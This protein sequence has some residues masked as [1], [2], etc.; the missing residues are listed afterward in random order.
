VLLRLP[1]EVK[2]LFRE[3]LAEF[4]PDRAKHVMSLVQQSHDGKDN[5]SRFGHR[6]RGSGP[7]AELLHRRFRLAVRKLGF[8]SADDR[9]RLNTSAFRP[10]T[11]TGGQLTLGF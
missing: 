1:H 5:D 4:Y 9:H 3:W 11:P 2:E 6:M 7:Y 8:E 10:P